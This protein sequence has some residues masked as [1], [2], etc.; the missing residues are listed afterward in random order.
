MKADTFAKLLVLETLLDAEIGRFLE[1]PPLSM[2]TFREGLIARVSDLVDEIDALDAVTA[3]RVYD[4]LVDF[5]ADLPG[6]DGAAGDRVMDA[7]LRFKREVDRIVERGS[8]PRERRHVSTWAV[9]LDEVLEV[10]GTEYVAAFPPSGELRPHPYLPARMLMARAREAADHMLW[11]GG[12][13]EPA[14]L[15]D[16]IDRLGFVVDHQRPPAPVVAPLIERVQ[17][18]ARLYRPSSLTRV[19]RFVLG[20]LLRRPGPLAKR[21]LHLRSAK[22][23]KEPHPA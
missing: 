11:T 18:H 7:A 8:D 22:R 14:L 1:D 20:Q 21:R 2:D 19:G 6:E 3:G 12:V 5:L 17:R 4:A 10:L 15:R 23:A 13:T 16:Q 9:V